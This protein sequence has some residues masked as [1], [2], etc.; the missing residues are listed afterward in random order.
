MFIRVLGSGDASS[1][2]FNTSI[3]IDDTI[4]IDAG[5]TVPFQLFSMNIL[6]RHI[7]LTHYHGDHVLGLPILMLR[8]AKSEKPII[9]GFK[10]TIRKVKL[11]WN[12]T[13]GLVEPEKIAE[14]RTFEHGD[15]LQIE[16][17]RVKVLQRPHG[18]IRSA[19]FKFDDVLAYATDVHDVE[20]DACYYMDVDVLIHEVGQGSFH[21]S[22]GELAGILSRANPRIAYIIHYPDDFDKDGLLKE[23]ER[24]YRG[25]VRFLERG[26]KIVV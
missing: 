10:E 20:E 18:P 16:E 9:Y 4:L 23:V 24:V 14:F 1:S 19:V 3:L 15:I 13:Y 25:P 11:L 22:V 7:L 6:P 12:E 5:P 17:Y 8:L 2:R 21:T 26:M